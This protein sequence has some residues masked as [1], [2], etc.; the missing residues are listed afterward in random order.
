M[1]TLKTLLAIFENNSIN[2]ADSLFLEVGKP[3]RM[4]PKVLTFSRNRGQL[5]SLA[6]AARWIYYRGLADGFS[7]IA[8]R[9]EFDSGASPF[10]HRYLEEFSTEEARPEDR[11]W[12]LNA[13]RRA[14]EEELPAWVLLPQEDAFIGP[15][16]QRAQ[17]LGIG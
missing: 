15:V 14:L 13:A 12:L 17:E 16:R 4:V 11:E 2:E 10:I 6:P 8:G 1:F 3:A 7:I 9:E 5:E